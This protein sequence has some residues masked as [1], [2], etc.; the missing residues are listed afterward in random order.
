MVHF[1]KK[2]SFRIFFALCKKLVEKTIHQKKN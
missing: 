2:E 1:A